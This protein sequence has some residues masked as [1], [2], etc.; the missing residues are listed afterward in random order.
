MSD[1]EIKYVTPCEAE[2]IYEK[3]S[4]KQKDLNRTQLM[5]L[6]HNPLYKKQNSHILGVSFS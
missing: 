3:L 5:L 1:Y 2:V 6:S 4:R